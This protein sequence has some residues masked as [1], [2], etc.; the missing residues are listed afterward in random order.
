MMEG[1]GDADDDADAADDEEEEIE[2]RS[3][4]SQ[5]S[6]RIARWKALMFVNLNASCLN[7]SVEGGC[8]GGSTVVVVILLKDMSPSLTRQLSSAQF[9]SMIKRH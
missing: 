6:S 3:T 4:W 8:G 1:D 7:P 2:I 9:S 5:S